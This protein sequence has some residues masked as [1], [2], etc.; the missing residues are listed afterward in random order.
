RTLAALP[1]P[2]EPHT[3][4]ARSLSPRHG[5]RLLDRLAWLHNRLYAPTLGKRAILV[6]GGSGDFCRGQPLH[7]AAGRAP[8]AEP[9]WRSAP[10][11][12]RAVP[13]SIPVSRTISISM[14]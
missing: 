3:H 8:S 1:T 12:W 2:G 9:R 4:A 11:Q 7:Q 14:S 10:I 6:G 5:V 13:I